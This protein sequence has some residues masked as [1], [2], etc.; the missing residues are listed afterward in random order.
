[1]PE[2]INKPGFFPLPREYGCHHPQ[3]EPP[4][5]LYI[6][7]GQGYRHVCP[8]CGKTFTIIPQQVTM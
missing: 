5:H 6:P 4:S 3:H 1:M 2:D 8:A 7:P